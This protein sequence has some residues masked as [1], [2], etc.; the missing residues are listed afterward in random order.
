VVCGPSQNQRQAVLEAV[1]GAM[2]DIPII[3][4]ETAAGQ[5]ALA[6][7]GPWPPTEAT[8]DPTL[9]CLGDLSGDDPWL[10]SLA[11]ADAPT[12][13]MVLAATLR[14]PQP[15]RAAV[16]ETHSHKTIPLK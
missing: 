13:Q 1:C 8:P 11:A 12:G 15:C 3:R 9:L 10:A 7:S 16:V 2:S 14:P 5:A 6:A 4:A